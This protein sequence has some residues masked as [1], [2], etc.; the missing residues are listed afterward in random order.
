MFLPYHFPCSYGHR[1]WPFYAS[2]IDEAIYEDLFWRKM[3]TSPNFV[4]KVVLSVWPDAQLNNNE[5]VFS[6]YSVSLNPESCGS[7]ISKSNYSLYESLEGSD[8]DDK[9]IDF[10][11]ESSMSMGYY[12]GPL[13]N[14]KT[15]ILNQNIVHNL[16]YRLGMSLSLN[17]RY[18][19]NKKAC[20]ERIIIDNY[21]FKN[22]YEK[23]LIDLLKKYYLVRY[24][25]TQVKYFLYHCEDGCFD[26]AVAYLKHPVGKTVKIAITAWRGNQYQ[27][28][29][30][31]DAIHPGKNA[32][33]YRVNNIVNCRNRV[34]TV[35]ICPDEYIFDIISNQHGWLKSCMLVTA[36]SSV[37]ETDWSV[38]H[39][40]S[41]VILPHSTEEGCREAYRL[42]RILE[43]QGISTRFINRLQ[44][45]K[46]DDWAL[47]KDLCKALSDSVTPLRIEDFAAFCKKEYAVEPPVGILPKAVSLLE[48]SSGTEREILLDRLLRLG[49]QM[50]LYARRGVGKSLFSAF[51]MVCFASGKKALDGKICPS[52]P[53]RVL[54]IDGELSEDDLQQRFR[55]I[56]SGLGLSKDVLSNI[57][58]RS[59]IHERKDLVLDTENG[60]AD[61][62]PDMC[63]ADIIVVDSLF[64]AFP[65][66][67][68][69]DF[70]GTARLNDFYGW[71]KRRG[72]TA[73]VVDHQGKKGDTPFG[74]MGKDIGLDVV[75]QLIGEKQD[76]TLKIMK[77]RNFST[78]SDSWKKFR[79]SETGDRIFFEGQQLAS[80][81]T[82]EDNCSSSESNEEEFQEIDEAS[83][84]D[85]TSREILKYVTE[86]SNLSQKEIV[87][88][89][90]KVNVASRSTIYKRLSLLKEKGLIP[91][92]LKR[93][94]DAEEIA[95]ESS[96]EDVDE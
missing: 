58:V 62:E 49:D 10:A 61:L 35:L 80:L 22:I 28:R 51:L 44:A 48:L 50:T 67:M 21:S 96:T 63:L 60:W 95:K 76:K 79:I 33:L 25:F 94:N 70:S 30:V 53:Y 89:L 88:N 45:E 69:T 59:A 15:G 75:L 20:H 72:K 41:P 93:D 52:R 47:G 2:T 23:R 9:Y 85:D 12:L 13:I 26:F 64:L 6:N 86:H 73:I 55:A 32:S 8:C 1:A 81:S 16:M 84:L 27:E 24:G 68:G 42:Y 54:L 66:A 5:I 43:T 4:K 3:Q 39:G 17:E 71:C 11:C 78:H 91:S 37:E 31:L 74:S 77:C 92:G 82:H 56:C 14:I 57:M 38:L 18:T 7:Y 29:V 83:S 65:S 36:Y 87:E 34:Q 46:Y 40:L 90:V 19:F